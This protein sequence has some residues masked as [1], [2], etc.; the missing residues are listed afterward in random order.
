MDTYFG[1]GQAPTPVPTTVGDPVGV[2]SSGNPNKHNEVYALHTFD[3][4]YNLLRRRLF[5]M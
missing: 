1:E 2:S 3:L 4:W 5:E